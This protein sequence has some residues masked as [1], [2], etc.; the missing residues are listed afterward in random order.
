MSLVT[1]RPDLLTSAAIEA[2]LAAV[3]T[4]VKQHEDA[5]GA[6]RAVDTIAIREVLV[7]VPGQV[8]N[9]AA[10]AGKLSI[11]DSTSRRLAAVLSATA[12]DDGARDAMLGLIE[13]A[14]TCARSL[15]LDVKLEREQQ[16]LD[17]GP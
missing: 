14:R 17:V 5:V 9:A 3:E 15:S 16:L 8:L 2:A 11:D 10:E 12:S 7:G 13:R 4:I 1:A 6:D